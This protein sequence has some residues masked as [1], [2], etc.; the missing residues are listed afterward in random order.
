VCLCCVDVRLGTKHANPWV[1][2]VETGGKASIL[3]VGCLRQPTRSRIDTIPHRSGDCCKCS[4]ACACRSGRD[5][6]PPHLRPTKNAGG[7][8]KKCCSSIPSNSATIPSCFPCYLYLSS[9]PHPPFPSLSLIRAVCPWSLSLGLPAPPALPLAYSPRLPSQTLPWGFPALS[10]WLPVG[11]WIPRNCP[12][13]VFCF[14][15]LGYWVSR[16]PM[17]SEFFSLG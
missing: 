15:I 3:E 10:R 16:L 12:F 4:N 2:R 7:S 5:N 6:L 14:P 1:N 8:Y 9:I 17:F 13:G 11:P